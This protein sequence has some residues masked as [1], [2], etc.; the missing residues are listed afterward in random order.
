MLLEK[1]AANFQGKVRNEMLQGKKYLVAPMTLV[2]PGVLNGSRGPLL[3]QEEDLEKSVDSWNGMPIV[4]N[5]P[6][7]SSGNFLSARSPSVL[8]E[9]GVGFVFNTIMNGKLTAEAWLDEQRVTQVDSR[10][11][12][13]I[14]G[15][16]PMDI[17]TGLFTTDEP[18]EGVH[19]ETGKSYEAI[20][21]N[22]RP[23]HLAILPDIDGACS[24]KDGCGLNVNKDGQDPED[25]DSS[26]DSSVS[27]NSPDTGVSTVAKLT[28]KAKKGLVDGII[29]NCDCWKEDDRETLNAMDDRA[30]K[31]LQSGIE[32]EQKTKEQEAVVNAATKGFKDQDGNSYTFNQET[33]EWEAKKVEEPAGTPTNNS[34]TDTEPKKQT[35]EEWYASAPPEVQEVVANAKA[36]QDGEKEKIISNLLGNTEDENKDARKIYE[37]MSLNQLK[38]IAAT[39]PKKQSTN[40]FSADYSGAAAP[41][42]NHGSGDL[43]DEDPLMPPT[44]NWAEE[45]RKRNEA[46]A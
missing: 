21:R 19:N 45:G 22:H 1:L 6:T 41:T 23:D 12:G 18:S 7:D 40:P 25:K 35:A 42:A 31:G 5:H 36:I 10:I 24:V 17:S 2:V 43:D 20:A 27:N 39:Q 30:L 4:V 11:L 32:A 28:A 8:E 9:Y 13:A 44:V 3:Y 34:A 15:G 37:G 46:V 26:A 38:T 16:K 29:A 14:R 33:G